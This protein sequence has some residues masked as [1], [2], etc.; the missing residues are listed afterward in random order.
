MANPRR[1]RPSP[2][3][4]TPR[5]MQQPLL[6][7]EPE[8]PQQEASQLESWNHADTPEQL[9]QANTND[10]ETPT[11]VD[12]EGELQRTVLRILGRPY[13]SKGEFW[14]QQLPLSIL[15]GALLGL[16]TFMFLLG[17]KQLLAVWYTVDTVEKHGDWKWL[18]ITCAGGLLSALLLSTPYSPNPGATRTA[19]HDASDLGGNFL[20]APMLLLS[21]I[22]C[23]ASGAPLGPELAIGVLGSSLGAGV[24]ELFGCNPRTTK[25]LVQAGMAGA[26][27]C[28]L[29]SPILGVLLVHELVVTG[30]GDRLTIDALIDSEE[31]L[32]VGPYDSDYMEHLVLGGAAA[33]TSFIATQLLMLLMP[34]TSMMNV[35]FDLDGEYAHWHLAAAIPLGI[36]CGVAGAIAVVLSGMFRA[37]RISTCKVLHEEG[38]LPTFLTILLFP[39]LAGFGHGLFAIYNPLLVGSGIDWVGYLMQPAQHHEVGRLVLLAVF[40]FLSMSLCLGFGLVGGP[41]FPLIFAGACLGVAFGSILPMSLAVPACTAATAGSFVPVPFTLTILVY[42]MFSLDIHQMG[43]VFVATISAFSVVG[44]LGVLRRWG[45]QRTPSFGGNGVAPPHGNWYE[46]DQTSEEDI[47]RSVRTMIFGS[48]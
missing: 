25:T 28:L 9:L 12:T 43:P 24:A 41:V 16:G 3:E 2:Y 19:F 33:S 27:G 35:E 15:L 11:R 10:A 26:F 6:E 45:E 23:L 1:N 14:S 13:A 5:S 44:G 8:T 22:I 30:R 7:D 20:E 36:C 40:K 47:L 29:S 18:I 42:V 48:N 46:D 34:H 39:T 21:C 37:M 32:N 38:K 17:S 4:T 31:T